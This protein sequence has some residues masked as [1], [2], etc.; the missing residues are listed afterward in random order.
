MKE[1][2]EAAVE[3]S[4]SLQKLFV[5]YARSHKARTMICVHTSA[6]ANVLIDGE[7][8]FSAAEGAGRKA[9]D[10]ALVA[11]RLGGLVHAQREGGRDVWYFVMP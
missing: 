3:T 4:E 2:L 5:D 6:D 7:C 11:L 8:V 9:I 1:R 10:D